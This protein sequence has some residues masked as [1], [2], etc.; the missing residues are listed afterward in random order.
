MMNDEV[1]IIAININSEDLKLLLT[2][3][4]LTANITERVLILNILAQKHSIEIIYVE[5]GGTYSCPAI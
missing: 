3:V 2:S 4:A 5:I 1:L